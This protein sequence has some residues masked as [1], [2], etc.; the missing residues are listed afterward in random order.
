LSIFHGISSASYRRRGA[1]RV[2]F[3]RA[4]LPAIA[5]FGRGAKVHGGL[6]DAGFSA[7]GHHTGGSGG[8]APRSRR[9]AVEFRCVECSYCNRHLAR[10]VP[11]GLLGRAEVLS[12]GVSNRIVFETGFTQEYLWID[13]SS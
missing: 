8:P 9:E 3:S 1:C 12:L 2:A 7:T 13:A 4:F 11:H 6:R 5:A 10:V